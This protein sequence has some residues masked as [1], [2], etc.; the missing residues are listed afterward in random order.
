VFVTGEKMPMVGEHPNEGQE[1]GRLRSTISRAL[2]WGRNLVLALWTQPLTRRRAVILLASFLACLY[3]IAVLAYVLTLPEIGVR[4]AF[5]PVVNHFDEEFLYP[6][7]QPRL[8]EGDS[9]VG[10]G[11]Q[12]VETWSQFLRKML[13]LREEQPAVVEQLTAEDLLKGR[14]PDRITYLQLDGHRVV[15]VTWKRAGETG[16]E[17][18]VVWLRLGRS[19]VETLVPGILWFFLNIGLFVV[20]ALVHWKRPEDGPSGLFF[21][22]CLVTLGAFMGGYHWSRIVTQSVL[23]A[24]FMA[25]AVLLP[26]V[27]LHFYLIFPR[28]KTFIEGRRWLV[29]LVIYGPPLLFLMLFV[30]GYLLVR[31]LDQGGATG[32]LGNVVGALQDANDD[33]STKVKFQLLLLLYQIYFYFGIAALWYLGSIASLLHSFV[34]ARN[35]IERNQVKWILIGSAASLLPIGYT[36]HMAFWQSGRFGAGGATWPMFLA[37]VCITLAYTFSIT[38]YR[39]LELDQMISSGAIYFLISALAGTVYYG[40]VFVGLLLVGSQVSEGPSLK[41]VLGVTVAA[42]V[43]MVALDL[44]RGRLMR[45]VAKHL[46]KEKYLLDRTLQCMS[47][48]IDQLVDPPTLARQLLHTTTDLLSASSGAIYLRQ[49]EPG[50]YRLTDALGETPS[51]VELSQGCPL[52]E[53]VREAGVLALDQDSA[54]SASRQLAFLHG[55]VAQALSHEGQLL[56]LLILGPRRTGEYTSEDL[57][58]L[59]AFAQVNKLALLSAEGHRTIEKLSRDLREKV[60]KIA[61]QQRRILALQSQVAR[62]RGAEV[63]PTSSPCTEVTSSPTSPSPVPGPPSSGLVGSSPQ[64]QQLLHLVR[65]VATSSSVVLLR[66]ESGTGKE[67]LARALHESSPRKDRPFVKV[68]CAALSPGLLESELFG[69][70]KG[71]FTSAIRDKV[72][73]FEAADGGTLFLDE[74]GD[75][76]LEVQTKLLRVLEEMT[77]ERVGSSEPLHVDVRII[78]A[79]HRDLEA[80]ITEGKFREDLYFRLNV[81]PIHVPPLRER[82]E[83]VVELAQHFLLQYA[84]KLGKRVRTIEDDALVVLKACAWPGNVRQLENVI[85]RAVVITEGTTIGLDE[86]PAELRS[87]VVDVVTREHAS[88]WSNNDAAG[89]TLPELNSVIQTER[90]EKEKR[91][92]EQLVRALAAAGGN[93]AVAA[94]ALGMARSTLISRL[95]K[96]GLS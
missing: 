21:L 13:L 8:R 89:L 86:L 64:L 93:K 38:R 42:L 76:N 82:I 14:V 41:H 35:A 37:S 31:W 11:N 79:T 60:E 6:E 30:W 22:L 16:P 62:L 1:V 72:G 94:R 90:A 59:S 18:G 24:V 85:E 7:D 5:T 34:T 54:S 67:L 56:G 65:R 33:P 92:R 15:R 63:V 88:T 9:I 10:L 36:L 83:D 57:Q 66:G 45:V 71:A 29:L 74:I 4:T 80:M 53:A 23:I 2:G 47:Q 91:E 75:I 32:P 50:L 25:C 51:L 77:F 49:G 26:A 52:I 70:V 48:A 58:V 27:T 78:A 39:L 81:L 73:R 20:G 96:F 40:V 84:Q 3:A 61:E 69:H 12:P 28:A 46:R 17:S 95:K 55:V 68:H 19:P 43:L 44:I 87:V